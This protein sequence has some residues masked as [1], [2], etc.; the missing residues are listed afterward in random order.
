MVSEP[1]SVVVLIAAA[2]LLGA[3]PAAYLAGKWTRGIDIR[4]RG[5][6]N[7]GIA[8]LGL[9][10]SWRVIVPVV[11]FDLGKG[12]VFLLVAHRMRLSLGSQTVIGLAPIVGHAWSVYLGFQGGRGVL[13]TMSVAFTLPVLNGLI[14]WEILVYLTSA[15]ASLAML[16]STPVGVIL[17]MAS[18]PLISVASGKPFSITLGFLAMFGIMLTRRLAARRSIEAA[19]LD[20]KRL[21][22][23]RALLDRDIRDRQAWEQRSYVQR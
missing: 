22:I 2:Y 9:I 14:P 18:F 1:T 10:T 6:G 11:V 16:H 8:N 21:V 4:K 23:Y 13:T 5:T 19:D 20:W 15:A 7:V 12:V 3:V 17:G